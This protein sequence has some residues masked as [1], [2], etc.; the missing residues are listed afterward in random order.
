MTEEH[1]RLSALVVLC[2][3]LSARRDH[4]VGLLGEMV[5]ARDQGEWARF[6]RLASFLVD[7]VAATSMT[8]VRMSQMASSGFMSHHGVY[9]PRRG[10]DYPF[11][12]EVS[13]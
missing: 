4:L 6:D 13:Q 10:A 5:A 2:D 3:E 11:G 8:T 9:V 1:S 12:M 7:S